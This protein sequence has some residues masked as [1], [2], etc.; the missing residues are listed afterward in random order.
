MHFRRWANLSAN[1]RKK[2][3]LLLSICKA[4]IPF[5]L[6]LGETKLQVKYREKTKVERGTVYFRSAANLICTFSYIKIIYAFIY[7]YICSKPTV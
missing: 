4:L 3:L 6:L 1:T 2:Y 7:I 5:Q